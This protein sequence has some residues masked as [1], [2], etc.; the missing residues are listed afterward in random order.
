MNSS[1]LIQLDSKLNKVI[2]LERDD[3]SHFLRNT[4]LAGTIGAGGLY[5]AGRGAVGPVRPGAMGVLD[6]MR[7]GAGRIGSSVAGATGGLKDTFMKG[8]SREGGGILRGIRGVARSLTKGRSRFV[9]LS[10]SDQ[11]VRLSEKL[12]KV[13][14]FQS[15]PPENDY[16]P[17]YLLGTP[18][19]TAIKAKK[20]QKWEGFKE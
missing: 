13:L 4:A 7:Q 11:I 6:T 16:I 20:G 12:D 5:A 19:M 9:G 18:L 17:R 14:E 10:S 3:E 2:A 1:Q 15:Q 8:Y